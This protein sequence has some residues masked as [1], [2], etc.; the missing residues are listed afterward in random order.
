MLYCGKAAGDGRSCVW[1]C[2]ARECRNTVYGARSHLFVLIPE[3]GAAS[4]HDEVT[5]EMTAAVAS[6]SAGQ[7][8]ASVGG[9]SES[10]DAD[11]REVRMSLHDTPHVPYQRGQVM[12][13][14]RGLGRRVMIK[15]AK[16]ERTIL[17]DV[18]GE[19][20]SGVCVCMCVCVCVCGAR[21]LS[22]RLTGSAE[23]VVWRLG[24]TLPVP[25][26]YDASCHVP[27]VVL[28]LLDVMPLCGT[29]EM[30]AIMG[31]SGAGKSTMLD[32]L[33]QRIDDYDGVR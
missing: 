12:L 9:R 8:V 31:P 18:F 16:A 27:H 21:A 4:H 28:Q 33:A 2:A 14:W 11:A 5:V 20:V 24:P 19:V 3:N 23:R 13:Q 26:R 25:W 17:H 22:G 10:K 1:A 15:E 30:L 7:G 32:I 29:P 6:P